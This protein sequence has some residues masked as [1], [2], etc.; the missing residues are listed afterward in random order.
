MI[1]QLASEDPDLYAA[2]EKSRRHAEAEAHILRSSGRYPLS[3]WDKFNLYAVFMEHSAQLSGERGRV[4]IIV[5]AGFI[6]DALCSRLFSSLMQRHMVAQ[7]LEFENKAKLF[8]DV[9]SR[10]RFALVSLSHGVQVADFCF[11]N[12]G[13]DQIGDA[14]RHVP[15]SFEDVCR[16]SPN[17]ASCPKF[18][19]KREYLIARRCYRRFP[20]L[21]RHTPAA[22]PWDVS[23]DR[24]INVSDFSDDILLRSELDEEN[25]EADDRRTRYAPLYEGK[26]FH[27]YDH[28]FATYRQ[29]VP[30]PVCVE[31]LDKSPSEH[32]SFCRYIPETIASRRN[33]RL[34]S[35]PTFVVVRDI[36]NRT[37]ERGVI[38]AII[39][40]YITDYTVRVVQ[41]NPSTSKRQLTLTALLNSFVFDYLA[42]QRIGGTHLTNDVLEQL[43]VPAFDDIAQET[44]RIVPRALELTYTAW[45]LQAFAQNCGWSRPPFR[46]DQERRLLLRCELD[47]AFFHV[48]LPAEANGEWQPAEDETAEELARLKASFP[49]PRDAVDY[50][51]NTFPIVRRKDEKKYGSYR[52]KETILEIYDEMAEAMRTSEPYQTRLDPPPADPRCCHPAETRPAGFRY[53]RQEPELRKVAEEQQ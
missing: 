8:S 16:L 13:L 23:I 17:T 22:S 21:R 6:T 19:S 1:E 28:R 27:Q 4:G 51:M 47:A 33:P 34:G 49:T 31:V 40:A 26:L 39:P 2:W 38:A 7:V 37:N 42:R 53:E 3:A 5:K 50:I 12:Q 35:L 15:I 52:T 18:P 30:D 41:L 46:W 20:P 29:T 10:E 43:P 14:N 24:Y 32:I 11:D 44:T 45:D 36:T 25:Q 9:D 48:Y